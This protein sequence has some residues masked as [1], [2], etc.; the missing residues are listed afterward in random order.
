MVP[1]REL[2]VEMIKLCLRK[3]VLS[4][5]IDLY[6]EQIVA[7]LQSEGF[8]LEAEPINQKT[9]DIIATSVFAKR[10][11]IQLTLTQTVLEQSSD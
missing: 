9:I 5:S 8:D 4:S 10:E 3:T 2:M 7:L 1:I 11:E 6:K